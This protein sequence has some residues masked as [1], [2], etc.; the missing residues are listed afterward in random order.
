M[1]GK[2]K[3]KPITKPKKI[4]IKPDIL[5]GIDLDDMIFR[6]GE[7]ENNIEN[8]IINVDSKIAE[9]TERV[10]KVEARLGIG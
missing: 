6:L 1:A 10:E 9:I 3:T 2:A 8:V 4:D 7:A 5:S